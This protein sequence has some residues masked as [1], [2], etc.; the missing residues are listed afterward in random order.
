MRREIEFAQFVEAANAASKALSRALRQ[1]AAIEGR[2]ADLIR[3]ALFTDTEPAFVR[4][5]RAVV[6]G[7][8]ETVEEIWLAAL[9]KAALSAFDRHAISA[10]PDR[11]VASVEQVVTTRRTLLGTFMRPTGIRQT[12]ALPDRPPEPRP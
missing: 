10:L 8:G 3:E 4:A 9:R 12:L 6:E 11:D 2:A 1:A 7:D 5:V